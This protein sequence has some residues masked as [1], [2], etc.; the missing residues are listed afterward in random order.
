MHL[1]VKFYHNDLQSKNH[2]KVEQIERRIRMRQ[3]CENMKRIL[4]SGKMFQ[5]HNGKKCGNNGKINGRNMKGMNSRISKKIAKNCLRTKLNCLHSE[6]NSIKLAAYIFLFGL[7]TNPRNIMY[8]NP[9]NH[10]IIHHPTYASYCAWVVF[11]KSAFSP[12]PILL[13]LY[14]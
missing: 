7:E 14:S 13:K 4:N 9:H 10:L 3:L 12:T 11:K 2:F 1:A 8:T 5:N 6:I